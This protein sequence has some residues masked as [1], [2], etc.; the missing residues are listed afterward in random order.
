MFSVGLHNSA[1]TC[2][3]MFNPLHIALVLADDAMAILHTLSTRN[4]KA[5]HIWTC[6]F[7]RTKHFMCVLLGLLGHTQESKTSFHVVSQELKRRIHTNTHAKNRAHDD[8]DGAHIR[9]DICFSTICC[10]CFFPFLYFTTIGFRLQ[11]A[12]RRAN[13]IFSIINARGKSQRATQRLTP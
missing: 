10:S 1:I 8:D 5:H 6:I 7:V 9:W 4:K 11:A 12:Q 3:F 2:M 13:P